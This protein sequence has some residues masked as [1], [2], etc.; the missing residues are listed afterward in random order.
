M[1]WTH[2][3]ARIHTLLKT[4][5]LLPEGVSILMAVSGG[6]DSLCLAKL[7]LDLKPKWGWSLAIVH[8]DHGWRTDSAEN[9]AH[10]VQLAQQFS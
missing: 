7:L 6:Q 8:C 3:H 9:A 5:V 1:A 2:T 10:V 4:Q